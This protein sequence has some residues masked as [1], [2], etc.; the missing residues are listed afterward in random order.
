MS[1]TADSRIGQLAL[2]AAAALAAVLTALVTFRAGNMI[3]LFLPV[4]MLAVPLLAVRILT[5]PV[6]I[7]S[8]FLVLIINLDFF[9]IGDSAL[10]LDILLS[11]VLLYAL[12]V[13]SGL[14]GWFAFRSGVERVYLLY[15][16]VT[17]VSV[18][19]SVHVPS[20][21]KNWGRDLEYLIL[22]AFLY[23]LPMTVKD[24]KMIVGA[25]I[26]SSVIPC[27][28][29]ILGKFLNISAFY[30]ATTPVGGGETVARITSTVSHPVVFSFY[31]AFISV[32]TLSMIVEG[33]MFRRFYMVPV[34]L[35]Q[36]I[37][38]YWTFGRTGWAELVVSII[39]LFMWFGHRRAV[40]LFIPIAMGGLVKLLPALQGRIV[41]ALGSSDNSLLWRFGLWA[42]SLSIFPKRPIFGSGQDTFLEYVNYL[43][44]FHA[45]QTWIGLLVEIGA[46]GLA[47]FAAL[48]ITVGVALHRRR[49]ELPG[50]PVIL[51]VSAA[52][53]GMIVGSFVGDTFNNPASALYLWALL[54]LALRK[55][56][57]ETG[58]TAG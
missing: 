43:E 8:I 3:F 1:V 10:T 51:G 26:L 50:D 31:L 9:K 29:G 7:V 33:R 23:T 13:R 54:P 19:L 41:Q 36:V 14:G 37:T 21:V 22:F 53:A 17:L 57:A 16:A 40:F 39:L 12:L 27:L 2:P 48:M 35:L 28:L 55:T 32:F 52:W 58:D 18:I 4:I 38:L 45:H 6:P 11:S 34:F 46:V 56:E 49:K 24:R 5:N 25:C 20:S 15:L 42:Y 44:G 47:A 30:G